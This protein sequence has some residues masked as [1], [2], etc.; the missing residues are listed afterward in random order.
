LDQNLHKIYEEKLEKHITEKELMIM[1]INKDKTSLEI[2]QFARS[3]GV[4]NY[5]NYQLFLEKVNND[6]K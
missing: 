3:I 2:S 5:Q 6:K 4:D 1:D